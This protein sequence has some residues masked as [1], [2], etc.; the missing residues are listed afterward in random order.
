MELIE[1]VRKA[2]IQAILQHQ[3]LSRYDPK[4]TQ[5]QKGASGY[6][7]VIAGF[8]VDI[9]NQQDLQVTTPGSTFGEFYY[10]PSYDGPDS[11]GPIR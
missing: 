4:H 7:G 2:A 1:I 5:A 8:P 10:M 9:S 6:E 11:G 3:G